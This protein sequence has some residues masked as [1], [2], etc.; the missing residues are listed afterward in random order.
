LEGVGSLFRRESKRELLVTRLCLRK[1]DIRERGGGALPYGGDG[2]RLKCSWRIFLVFLPNCNFG[3][4][5]YRSICGKDA[6]IME[7][8]SAYIPLL[9]M[10]EFSFSHVGLI[11]VFKLF[12]SEI[13]LSILAKMP[14]ARQFFFKGGDLEVVNDWESLALCCTKNCFKEKV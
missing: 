3:P 1:I 10:F 2:S 13:I 8:G 9:Q 5:Y 11:C 4:N 14:Q 7:E 6:G 12:L